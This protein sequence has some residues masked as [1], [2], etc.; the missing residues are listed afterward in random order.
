MQNRAKGQWA[1]WVKQKSVAT[2]ISHG[3]C[4]SMAYLPSKYLRREQDV[5]RNSRSRFKTVEL[6]GTLGRWFEITC[7]AYFTLITLIYAPVYN[8]L[9]PAMG[10]PPHG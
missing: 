5:G 6:I 4:A 3:S 10:K 1:V 2:L 7:M 9:F 8:I